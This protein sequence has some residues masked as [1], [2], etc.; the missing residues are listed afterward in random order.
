MVVKFFIKYSTSYIKYNV[1]LMS[2]KIVLQ[3]KVI[4][5]QWILEK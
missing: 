2:L 5:F 4:Q 3:F 1:F